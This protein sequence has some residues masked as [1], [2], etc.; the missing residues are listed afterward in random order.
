M[1][2]TLTLLFTFVV[3][4]SFAQ[5]QFFVNAVNGLSCRVKPD[6]DSEKVGK[7]PY[8]T[9]VELVTTTLVKLSITENKEII[10]GNW[11]KVKYDDFP[12]IVS[13]NGVTGFS[14]EVYVFNG[15]LEPL[16]KATIEIET[17]SENEF[18]AYHAKSIQNKSDRYEVTDNAKIKSLLLNKATWTPLDDLNEYLI[19]DALKLDNGQYLK[20][21]QESN[22][23]SVIAYYPS[24]EIL[25][26]EGGHTSDYSISIKT[27]ETL[28]TVGNPEYI[29]KSA[30]DDLQLNGH[31][32]GQECSNYFFQ[33]IKDGSFMYLTNFG[34]GSVNGDDVCN[35]KKFLWIK[36]KQFVYSYLAY[37]KDHDDGILK[38][39]KGSI[40][41][42]EK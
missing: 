41:K 24:E 29:I 22:D 10:E 8:G 42:N 16:N 26:F 13:T 6:A 20:I 4:L 39:K 5:E 2:T 36:K 1:K 21:N 33:E 40:I 18:K 28:T 31:F 9:I 12:F 38:Y 30:Y 35:F 15:Y 11:V 19:L 17:I 14:K 32:P 34:W 7:L 25:L 3:S 27:G 23:Y 37:S